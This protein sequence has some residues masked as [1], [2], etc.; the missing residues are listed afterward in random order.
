[1][2]PICLQHK[3][4]AI[5]CLRQMCVKGAADSCSKGT[6]LVMGN[7]SCRKWQGLCPKG[8]LLM[9]QPLVCEEISTVSKAPGYYYHKL[10]KYIYYYRS[11]YE[12]IEVSYI[13]WLVCSQKAVYCKITASPVEDTEGCNSRTI[14]DKARSDWKELPGTGLHLPLTTEFLWKAET[15]PHRAATEAKIFS[16]GHSRAFLISW[17]WTRDHDYMIYRHARLSSLQMRTEYMQHY[18]VAQQLELRT[19]IRQN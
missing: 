4:I 15:L 5:S 8:K 9:P 3:H 13:F 10:R 16:S 1:M 14:K 7:R 12:V 19:H 17:Y 2:G 11:S 6:D 18:D